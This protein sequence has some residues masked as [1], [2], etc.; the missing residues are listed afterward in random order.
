MWYP[1]SGVVLDC[2]DSG[3]LLPFLL[4]NVHTHNYDSNL[5]WRTVSRRVD[6]VIPSD[7]AKHLL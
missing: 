7:H 4:T 5:I 6:E 1:G 3:S 2:I